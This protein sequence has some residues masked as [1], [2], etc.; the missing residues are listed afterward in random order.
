MS[1]CR[2]RGRLW[3]GSDGAEVEV[4]VSKDFTLAAVNT[5]GDHGDHDNAGP[6]QP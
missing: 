6:D 2:R 5:M 4:Q 3:L 1:A